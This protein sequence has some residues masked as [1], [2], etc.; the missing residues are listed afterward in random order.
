MVNITVRELTRDWKKTSRKNK[1]GQAVPVTSDGKVIGTF[2][3]ADAV[4]LDRKAF[5]PPGDPAHGQRLVARML[6]SL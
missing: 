4:R 2:V 5:V 1:P 3:K 6:R